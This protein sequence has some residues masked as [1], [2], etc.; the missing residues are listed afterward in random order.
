MTAARESPAGGAPGIA[1]PA[2][3]RVR[4]VLKLYATLADHLPAEARTTHRLP[5]DVAA[6]TTVQQVIDERKLPPKLCHLVLVNGYYVAPAQRS[7]HA[8]ESGD[9]LA[10][11]P[12]IAGG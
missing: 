8:L 5:L 6:G 11:W 7:T 12:P 9:E 4:V 3:P 10:I 2:A 1:A